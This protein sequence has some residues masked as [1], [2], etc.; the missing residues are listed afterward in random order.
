ML[1]I[2]KRRAQARRDST[3]SAVYR[4]AAAR[5]VS[6]TGTDASAVA[7][8]FA[9]YQ[10]THSTRWLSISLLPTVAASA[11]L[12]P[13][14]GRIGD[15]FNRRR[16]MVGAELAACAVFLSLAMVHSPIA[17]LALGL[18]ASSIGTVFGPASGA[19]VAHVAGERHLSWANGVISTGSSVGK[20]AGRLVAGAVIAALGAASVFLLDAVTFLVSASLIASVRRAFSEPLDRPAPS[21]EPDAKAEGGM[22]FLLSS[23]S[24]RL[25]VASAC[26]STFATA[27]S[28]TAE[29]PL[30]FSL[31][32]GAV[33]L[34]ALTA[35]WTVGTIVASWYSRNA[36]DAENEATAVLGGRLTM[37]LGVGLV[38]LTH[39][40]MPAL[41][42]YLLGGFGGG[43]M[44]VAAQS[45]TVRTTPDRLRARTLAAIDTC[46][47][48]T[49]GLGVLGAGALVGV[50]GAR[51][52]YAL[53]GVGMAVATLPVATLVMRQGGPR[54]LR[55]PTWWRF[56]TRL[57][58]RSPAEPTPET[59]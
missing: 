7:I 54:P 17:L 27:F 16:V 42:C 59:G 10:Q 2:L 3:K 28:M 43:L 8:G 21:T 15:R 11:L 14:A 30:A 23:P 41:S 55:A 48:V 58:G 31:G 34:G 50:A 6:F 22:R 49:F 4:L 45:L 18:A 9:M 51:P 25:V 47:N 40:L 24:L 32:A 46:R 26:I 38:A 52:I 5:F 57:W 44:G 36:L 33:G 53:V 20:T 12:A 29:V 13:L 19:A 39:S 1:A 56:S 37:A 35:C